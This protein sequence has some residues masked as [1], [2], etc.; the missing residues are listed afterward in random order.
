MRQPREAEASLELVLEAADL[1]HLVS[2][3]GLVLGEHEAQLL[4]E[5]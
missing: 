3:V 4:D 5:L 2:S 1:A